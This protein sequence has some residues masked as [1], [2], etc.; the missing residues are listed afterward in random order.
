MD[1]DRHL[2]VSRFLESE[3]ASGGGGG[4]GLKKV[5]FCSKCLP[6]RR[7]VLNMKRLNFAIFVFKF[8]NPGGE[9]RDC[10]YKVFE[11]VNEVWN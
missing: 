8:Y 10:P 2:R 6:A 11:N 1:V 9:G 4:R 7:I 5:E 3:L